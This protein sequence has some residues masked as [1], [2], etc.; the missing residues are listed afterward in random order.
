M[1]VVTLEEEVIGSF[2]PSNYYFVHTNSL[3]VP[4]NLYCYNMQQLHPV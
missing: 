3:F 1:Q 2:S 4:P